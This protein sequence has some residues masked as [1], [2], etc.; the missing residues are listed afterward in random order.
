[1]GL[2]RIPVAVD[3][4]VLPQETLH[5]RTLGSR[6]AAMNEPHDREPR[7]AGGVQI[8]VDH[9]HDV[10]RLKGVQIDGVFD[11]EMNRFFVHYLVYSAVTRVV[12]PPRAVK[13]P[14]TV[15]RRGDEAAT[16]SSRILFVT[17]S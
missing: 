13:S 15:M 10:T 17:A 5:R 2:R 11:R 4:L 8:L 6:A 16:R 14:M 7:L 12:S 3:R 1:M 9:S